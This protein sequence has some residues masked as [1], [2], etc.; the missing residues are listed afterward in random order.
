MAFLANPMKASQP[1]WFSAMMATERALPPEPQVTS[2]LKVKRVIFVLPD[3]LFAMEPAS[4][5]DGASSTR[6]SGREIRKHPEFHGIPARRNV[7]AWCRLTAYKFS[8]KCPRPHRDH[9]H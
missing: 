7:S 2:P 4:M 8:V 6:G 1:S 9:H 5:F 3:P